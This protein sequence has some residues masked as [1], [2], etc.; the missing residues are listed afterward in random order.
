MSEVVLHPGDFYFT[1]VTGHRTV[2]RTLLGSC[3]AITLWHPGFG[4]GGMCHFVVP[5]RGRSAATRAHGLDGRYAEE[6]VRMFIEA[7]NRHG[8]RPYEYEVGLF[9]GGS[10]FP[11]QR[12]GA[13]DVPRKNVAAGRRLLELAGFH[14]GAEHVGGTGPRVVEL[15]LATGTIRLRHNEDCVGRGM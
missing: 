14:V 7:V 15:D 9:G 12:G 11:S 6:A 8:T 1:R 3:V 10:Q 2:V 4:I 13:L 5:R